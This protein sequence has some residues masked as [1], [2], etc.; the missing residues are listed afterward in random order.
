MRAVQWIT[1]DDFVAIKAA[2]LNHV[3]YICI[4]V[5]LETFTELNFTFAGYPWDTGLSH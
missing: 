2:G 4:R 1:E 5:R 3:R